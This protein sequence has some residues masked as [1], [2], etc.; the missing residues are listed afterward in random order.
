[1]NLSRRNRKRIAL[2]SVYGILAL[3]ITW[4]LFRIFSPMFGLTNPDADNA[5]VVNVMGNV[6]RPGRYR[7]PAGT[8]D[9]E[10][11]KVA[12]IRPTSDISA[13]DLAQQISNNQQLQVGT[14]PNPV[15]L[16][17]EPDK[18]RLE[19]HTSEVS[20]IASDGRTRQLETGMEINQGDRVLTEEKS[21]AE[22]SA[23]TFSRIDLD[24]FSELVFDKI[25]SV[26]NGKSTTWPFQKS[27]TVWYKIVYGSKTELFRISTSLVNVTV[28]GNGADFTVVIKPD[29]IDVNNMD[30]L[31]LVERVNGS[32][33]I[34]L[35]SGQSA[36]VF[37]DG[38]P[39]QVAP[40]SPETYPTARFSVLTKEKST[41]LLRH[42]P[43]N[44]VFCG[45]PAIYYFA[46]IDFESG[47]LNVV[48]LPLDLDVQ[49]F[50]Q[51]CAT[52]DQAFLYGGGVYVSTVTEQIMGTRIPKYAVLEKNDIIRIAAV[53]GGVK[54]DVD[55]KAAAEMK[56][57]MGPQK[58]SSAQLASFLRLS[59][60][61]VEDSKTRQVKVMKAILEGLTSK[62]IVLSA[63]AAQEIIASTQ[64]NISPAELMDEYGKFS[65]V[66]SWKFKEYSLPVKRLYHAG[67]RS[68]VPV[69][70]ECRAL[71]QK[72]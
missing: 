27:G 7:V 13:F 22:L 28:A 5:Y 6:T 37:S 61:G 59:I 67:R 32:E 14:M 58:L 35:I 1:M 21:Q 2:Y 49:E 40:M 45:V 10:I 57:R 70:E 38:R 46:S 43:F 54:I 69:L 65:T 41:V 33:A 29:E 25:G 24:N 55:E 66:Q 63:L 26:E 16:K 15:T 56:L 42:M 71:L 31:V 53:L 47:K 51:G 8:T 52:L 34:N 50:M 17:K 3:A 20:V 19:F 18:I 62:N 12:G 11:L 60:S 30:G 72:E 4:Q 9:F 64:T 68:A 44:F 39:F 23:S 48:N 36:A